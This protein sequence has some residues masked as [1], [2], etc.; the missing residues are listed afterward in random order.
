MAETSKWSL[1][2]YPKLSAYHGESRADF[3]FPGKYNAE[4]VVDA[5]G[6]LGRVKYILRYYTTY[7]GVNFSEFSGYNLLENIS[8]V[9]IDGFFRSNIRMIKR[10]LLDIDIFKTPTGDSVKAWF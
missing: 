9:S 6:E 8:R 2:F 4:S 7:R 10:V 3:N 1:D 5:W